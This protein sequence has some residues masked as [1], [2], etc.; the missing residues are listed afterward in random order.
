MDVVILNREN[1]KNF[2]K[3]F[4]RV[5]GRDPSDAEIKDHLS[6]GVQPD[7]VN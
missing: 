1:A 5:Y 3:T 7:G 4:Q 2:I 6:C